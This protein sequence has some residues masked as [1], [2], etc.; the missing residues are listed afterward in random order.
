MFYNVICYC[1]YACCHVHLYSFEDT[2]GAAVL[3]SYHK[4]QDT[5]RNG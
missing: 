4:N 3:D 2:L 1:K 5:Y